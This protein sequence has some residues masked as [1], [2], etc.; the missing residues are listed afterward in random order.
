[1]KRSLPG[2]WLLFFSLVTFTPHTL[3]AAE[4]NVLTAQVPLETPRKKAP[5]GG[6]ALDTVEVQIWLPANVKVIRGAIVNPFYTKAV[7]QQHWQ[8]ACRLWGF[9]VVG[10]NYFDVKNDDCKP[11]L[12]AALKTFAN[13]SGHKEIEHLPLCFVGMSA[14]GGMSAK[15]ADLLPERTIAAAPVCLEVGPRSPASRHIPM[16]TIFGEKDGKQLE[17][18]LA[19]LPVER[20][21]RARWAI[22]IQWGRRHE[23]GQANN[24]ILPFF[25]A[26]IRMRYPA[27]ANPLSGPV[28]LQDIPEDA[29]YLGDAGS[30]GDSEANIA[31]FY[32]YSG[33]RKTACWFPD[34]RTAH[35]WKAFVGKKPALKLKSPAGLGDGQPFV[36]HQADMPITIELQPQDAD[37]KT[38]VH[39][40][41]GPST[42][43]GSENSTIKLSAGIHPLI[44]VRLKDG[45]R[46]ITRPHTLLVLPK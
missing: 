23:F 18:L 13:K 27:D 22:A 42:N 1:M 12:L 38:A 31:P 4:G 11:T 34:E 3:L 46:Q 20:A 32:K 6:G 45:T 41:T 17:K 35:T 30:W 26:C 39:F 5:R 8:A 21:A 16:I 14:G 36:V 15:F 2:C 43:I 25:D 33:D 40:G 24:L 29:G 44:G 37:A 7:T 19:K 28:K 9:A 10:A